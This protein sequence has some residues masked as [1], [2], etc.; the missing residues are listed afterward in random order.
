MYKDVELIAHCIC[1]ASVKISVGSVV[2]SLVS[3]YENHFTSSRQETEEHALEEM[4]I[5]ENGPLLQHADPTLE[6]A[7]ENYWKSGEKDGEWH[8]IRRSQNIRSYTGDSSAVGAH[9][10]DNISKLPFMES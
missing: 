8:F 2:E 6:K 1:V 3:R 7:M 9:M 10:F 5:A 4:I